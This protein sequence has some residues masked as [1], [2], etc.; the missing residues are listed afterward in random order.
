MSPL[1]R[2]AC[3]HCRRPFDRQTPKTLECSRCGIGYTL[4]DGIWRSADNFE[5]PGFS[6]A[7]RDHLL[8]L[9]KDH[10]WFPPRLKLVTKL[11]KKLLSPKRSALIELGCGTG[12]LLAATLGITDM[13]VGVDGHDRMLEKCL[14][15]GDRC[16]LIHADATRVPLESNQFDLV[17]ALDVLEHLEPMA[18]LSEARRLARPGGKLLVSVPAF[19]FL[20][21]RVDVAAGHRCRYHVGLIKKQLHLSGWRLAGYTHYQ[22]L[23]FPAVVISRLLA[24]QARTKLERYPRS[25]MNRIGGLINELEVN[26]LSGFRLPWGSS[27]IVRAEKDQTFG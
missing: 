7:T 25:W 13:Y 19:N 11:V 22:F 24:P 10:F 2:W 14:K 1:P 15:S 16:W 12:S 27:L 6:A 20:W 21:S 26:L 5:P 18:L 3:P 8:R 23:L 4:K 17:V 9:E